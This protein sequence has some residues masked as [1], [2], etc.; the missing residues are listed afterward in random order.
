MAW[1]PISN[2]NEM[3]ASIVAETQLVEPL[4]LQVQRG[5]VTDVLQRRAPPLVQ[6][7]RVQVGGFTGTVRRAAL[8]HQELEPVHVDLGGID[9]QLVAARPAGEGRRA[10]R[11]AEHGPQAAG[12][13]L[14]R[15]AGAPRRSTVPELVLELVS[16]N[17]PVRP[18]GQ[19]REQGAGLDT[20]DRQRSSQ[21]VLRCD[22]AKQ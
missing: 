1:P 22:A 16:G 21:S 15:R 5:N 14:D 4:G 8:R 18:H 9:L 12:V 3:R 10:A 20:R 19:Q 6:G 2:S 7:A 13:S 17:V 11:G